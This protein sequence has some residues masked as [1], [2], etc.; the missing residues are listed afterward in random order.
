MFFFSH[1]LFPAQ[2]QHS[3]VTDLVLQWKNVVSVS[4]V[5]EIQIPVIKIMLISQTFSGS[6][7]V[8]V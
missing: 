8:I 7:G 5:Q 2:I 1:T 3:L 6:G 4:S